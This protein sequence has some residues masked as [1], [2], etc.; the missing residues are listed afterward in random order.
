MALVIAVLVLAALATLLATLSVRV[1]LAK[2]RQN[3]MIEYQRARYALDSAMKYALS[4]MPEKKFELAVRDGLPDFSDLFWMNPEQR[5]MYLAQWLAEATDEQIEKILKP[6]SMTGGATELS[7]EEMLGNLTSIFGLPTDTESKAEEDTTET[8]LT[9]EQTGEKE[10]DTETETEAET[11]PSMESDTVD[12]TASKAASDMDTLGIVVRPEDLNIPGPYTEDWPNVT[13]PIELEIG[14]AKVT[15]TIEDENAKLPLAWAITADKEANKK[16]QAVLSAFYDWIGLDYEQRLL[17]A[18]QL[19]RIQAMKAFELNPNPILLTTTTTPAPQTDAQQPAADAAAA[20]TPQQKRLAERRARR[21]R[22]TP[23]A[24]A[25]KTTTSERPASAH[26]TDFAKLFHSALLDRQMLTRTV[27]PEDAEYLEQPEPAEQTISAENSPL[28]Y[29]ALWGSQR[30]NVN[31]APRHVL[32]AALTFGG[33]A[34]QL[35][36]LVIQERRVEPFKDIDDL[37]KR[38]YAYSSLIDRAKDY[39]TTTS[40]FY[41]IR[42][43]SCSGNARTTAVATVIKEDKKVEQLAILYGL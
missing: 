18:E 36:E 39:L 38:C 33:D 12:E 7:P 26:A 2:R 24:A 1:T 19:A 11:E 15:I 10:E 25:T 23:A 29:L 6:E 41:S 34:A 21:Q 3:Y 14:T 43:V 13:K 8:S 32:E 40:N 17:L 37:K 5:Q 4:A 35:T 42:V 9:D 27:R 30:V 22:K 16:A 28:R 31:S 20:Q